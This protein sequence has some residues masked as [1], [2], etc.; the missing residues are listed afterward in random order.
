MHYFDL[1]CTIF[2][3]QFHPCF[4]LSLPSTRNADPNDFWI[5]LFRKSMLVVSLVQC[6][7]SL[8]HRCSGSNNFGSST[9][10]SIFINSPKGHLLLPHT[11]SCYN[12]ILWSWYRISSEGLHF[13]QIHRGSRQRRGGSSRSQPSVFDVCHSLRCDLMISYLSS[14]SQSCSPWTLQ[15]QGFVPKFP[16]CNPAANSATAGDLHGSEAISSWFVVFTTMSPHS[17][18]PLSGMGFRVFAPW[19]ESKESRPWR[20]GGAE[21]V[22]PGRSKKPPAFVNCSWR[23]SKTVCFTSVFGM[24]SSK[25]HCNSCGE[26]KECRKDIYDEEEDPLFQFPLALWLW[27]IQHLTW[28]KAT[29]QLCSIL[30]SK[31][32]MERAKT[33]KFSGFQLLTKWCAPVCKMKRCFA[34]KDLV[35]TSADLLSGIPT[36][37]SQEL[38]NPHWINLIESESACCPYVFRP[39]Q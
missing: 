1:I 25:Q 32:T 30:G 5:V 26:T 38:P 17:L 15:N 39:R 6:K 27:Q 12:Q 9:R 14:C 28:I 11:W 4:K 22:W 3:L 33:R 7:L 24:P 21:R 35:R 2:I 8:R 16:S 23:G 34:Q 29:L 19:L 20:E 37:P 18:R 36:S 10:I 13:S 31:M